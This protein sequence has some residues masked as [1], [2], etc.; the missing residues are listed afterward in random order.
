[1]KA[2]EIKGVTKRYKDVLALDS[3]SFSFLAVGA[4]FGLGCYALIRR[5]ELK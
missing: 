2:I 3:V 1:M 5:T 4:V